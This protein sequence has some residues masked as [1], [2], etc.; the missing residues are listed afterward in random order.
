[1]I[2]FIRE[3]QG[4]I[5]SLLVMAIF[6]L[7]MN[8]RSVKGNVNAI[9]KAR[10]DSGIEPMTDEEKRLISKVLRSSVLTDSIGPLIGGLVALVV[11]YL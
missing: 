10:G 1:M 7:V 8:M 11:I 2:D 9:D 4:A 6:W 3:N 5:L